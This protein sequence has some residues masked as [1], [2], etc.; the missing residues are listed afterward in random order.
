MGESKIAFVISGKSPTTIPG[1]LGAY[2]YNVAKILNQLGFKVFIVGF[3]SAEEVVDLKF[4][5]LIHFRNPY[6]RLLGLGSLMATR[7]FVERMEQ[8]IIQENPGEIIVYSAGIWGLA[9]VALARRRSVK[10]IKLKTLVGYF[11]TLKHEYKGHLLGTPVRDYGLSSYLLIKSLYLFTR[12]F[13]SRV[14]GR[15]LRDTDLVVVHYDSTRSILLSEFSFLPTDKVVKI[16]Y[17]VDLY[18]RQSDVKFESITLFETSYPTVSVIC[19]QDPRKGINTFLKAV[20]ILRDRGVRFNCVVAG[21][22]I[23]LNRNK[24]LA[25]KLGLSDFVKF[26]GFVASIESALAAT[27]IYVLPSVEEGSGAISLLEAMKKGVAIVTTKCDGIPEDFI[28]GR[29][30]ILVDADDEVKLSDALEKLLKDKHLRD[31]LAINVK[32]DYG[33]RFT[34]ENM[35]KGIASVIC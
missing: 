29:T 14:E 35:K 21:N 12:I 9:G 5:S 19:R 1:G 26:P 22:G 17:Y 8:I 4:A 15:M 2:S 11:T 28:D 33:R 27:D 3:S 32:T 16:P 18:E 25:R 34:F 24:S 20:R 13:Y 31:T 7:L 10:K 6:A 30:G 23:F